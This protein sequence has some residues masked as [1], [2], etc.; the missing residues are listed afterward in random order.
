MGIG[1]G[2]ALV[3][4]GTVREIIGSGTLFNDA[5]AVLGHDYAHWAIRLFNTNH[6]LLIALL[7]PGAFIFLGL[8]LAAK[9]R[10]DRIYR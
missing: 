8:M 4:L 9:N 5:H 10:I 6:A 3:M 2:I 1:F 7:P